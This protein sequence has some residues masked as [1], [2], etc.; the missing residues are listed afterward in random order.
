MTVEREEMNH[1]EE[2]DRVKTE[3][4]IQLEKE[5]EE[6]R[7]GSQNDKNAANILTSFIET[8][9]AEIDEN[10]MVHIIDQSQKIMNQPPSLH[11]SKKK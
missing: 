6:M 11:G 1:R 4:I 2:Y 8:G 5:L 10:G 9:Q 7:T 3:R